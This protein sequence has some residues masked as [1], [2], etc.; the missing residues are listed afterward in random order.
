MEINYL[1]YFTL[2]RLGNCAGIFF[3]YGLSKFL[4]RP[5]VWGNPISISIEPTNRCNLRCPQCPSGTGTLTRDAGFMNL[6]EFKNIIDQ[7]SGKTFYLQLFFQGEPYLNKSLPEMIEY[8]KKSKMYVAVSTNGLIFNEKNIDNI[9]EKAPDK[10]IFSL[11]GL[12][13]ETYKTYRIGGSF[14]N[15]EN[16]LKLLIE[17]KKAS[18]QNIPFIELQFLVMKKNEHQVDDFINYGKRINVDKVTLKTSQVTDFKDAENFLPQNREYSRYE[19]TGNDFKIKGKMKNGCFAL[20]KAAVITWDGICVPCC[21]DKDADYSSG[22]LNGRSFSEVWKS[23]KS[24]SFR[25]K[26]L[27]RRT[28][29]PMCSNCTSGIKMNIEEKT[30]YAG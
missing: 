17:K 15:A 4:R 27:N 2:E 16:S 1:K 7:I 3:S 24:L 30:I 8:A 12:D 26:I 10:I 23:E 19:K 14:R 20:W 13:E 28:E 22:R 11:D 6:N 25:S 18:G 29:I 21:F 9:I 5:V